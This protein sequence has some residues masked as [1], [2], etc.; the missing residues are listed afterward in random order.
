MPTARTELAI[1]RYR[2]HAAGC[3]AFAEL[4]VPLR[5]R[6]RVEYIA[7]GEHRKP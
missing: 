6:T 2:K 1:R 3:T 4:A 7:W 5:R